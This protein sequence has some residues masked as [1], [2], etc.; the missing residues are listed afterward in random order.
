[1]AEF[2]AR[3]RCF[4]GAFMLLL[5]LALV[6]PVSAQQPNQVN[7]QSEA[8][9][10]EQ[11]LQQ[12][13]TLDGRVTIPDRRAGTLIQPAGRDW[14]AFHQ[15]TLHWIGGIAIV[16]AGESITFTPPTSASSASRPSANMSMTVSIGISP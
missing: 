14:R 2:L 7:P 5:A 3:I 6:A 9:S 1:M 11:L 10:E 12:L 15:Q 13:Q 4:V 8:V 16:V